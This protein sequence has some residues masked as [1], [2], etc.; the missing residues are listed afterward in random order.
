MFHSPQ[1]L[2][3][4][5][6]NHGEGL[7]PHGESSVIHLLT[8]HRCI[9]KHQRNRVFLTATQVTLPSF[10]EQV[11]LQ[12]LE[13]RGIM[14]RNSKVYFGLPNCIYCDCGVPLC[15]DCAQRCTEYYRRSTFAGFCRLANMQFLAAWRLLSLLYYFHS[16]GEQ[17]PTAVLSCAAPTGTAN[18]PRLIT[19][20]QD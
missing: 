6:I 20:C 4:L 11:L 7:F 15:L 10:P 3:Q 19:C 5:A 2:L 12:G 18:H 8:E 9:S 16:L 14:R 1:A 17:A 13:A